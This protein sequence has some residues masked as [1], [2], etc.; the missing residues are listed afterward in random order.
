MKKK[1][2]FSICII[3][4]VCIAVTVVF[5]INYKNTSKVQIKQ[6]QPSQGFG[7][8][9][10][11]NAAISE[12]ETDNLEK[13]IGQAD[14]TKIYQHFSDDVLGSEE[15]KGFLERM[16]ENNIQVYALF[17][18]A[19]W[20][21]E[22]DAE[23]LIGKIKRVADYNKNNKKYRIVGVMVDVEPYLLD[24]WSEEGDVR[25]ELMEN[26]LECIKNAYQYAKQ[27]DLEFIVCVPTF[28]DEVCEDV[29]DSLVENACDGLAVM[30]YNRSDEYGQ[31]EAEVKLAREQNKEIICIYEL[32]EAGKHDL[33]DI[34]TYAGEGLEP[35][36]K[37]AKNLKEQFGYSKLSFSYH[38]YEPLKD[39]LA[40]EDASAKDFM[41]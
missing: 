39:L 7:M 3:L 32:Q 37:S 16:K 20:A 24:E 17:G 25:D 12:D 18:D 5:V 40:E 34:N 1:I 31:I 22:T 2:L 8:F 23:T 41:L 9:S 30:N 29:L 14:V 19:E 13:C 36:W 15:A 28:Y 35:L 33:E 4:I 38:Y 6:T 21:Y 27:N 11:G 10:W 26:Y